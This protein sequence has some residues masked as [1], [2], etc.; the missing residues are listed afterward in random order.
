MPGELSPGTYLE[1]TT[2]FGPVANH[3]TAVT[4][5]KFRPTSGTQ[6]EIGVKTSLLNGRLTGSFAYFKISQENYPVPNSEWYQ[7]TALGRNAEAALLPNPIYLDLSSKGWEFEGSYSLANNLTILGN[8][9]SFKERQPIT[10]VRVRAVPD[11]AY[12]LYLDYRFTEGAMK[13]FGVSVGMDYKGDVAG[14][15][16]TGYTTSAPIAGGVGF[17]PNQPSFL[18]GER[19]VVNVGF[20]YKA[21]DW[22]ARLQIANA[23]DED[24]VLA[25]GSRGSL[26]MADPRNIKTTFTYRF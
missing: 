19:T 18:V 26:I 3:A 6:D 10:N 22:T 20:S 5:Q 14:E 23:L 7:L 15:N 24:Y 1:N 8:Y 17:V 11:K 21:K 12:A 25:A 16:S 2:T 4:V 13:G 9:T